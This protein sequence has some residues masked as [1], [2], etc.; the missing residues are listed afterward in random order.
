[1][2]V[3]VLLLLLLLLLARLQAATACDPVAECLKQ[4]ANS[5]ATRRQ[6]AMRCNA[7]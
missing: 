7:F 6:L 2:V 4:D 5:S 3:V 1:M